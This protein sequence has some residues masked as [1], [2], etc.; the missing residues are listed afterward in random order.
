MIIDLSVKTFAHAR[1]ERLGGANWNIMAMR[2]KHIHNQSVLE[3]EEREA[4]K[5]L[6]SSENPP[7]RRVR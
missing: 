5:E 3:A 6:F 2:R 1:R 4:R 7:A